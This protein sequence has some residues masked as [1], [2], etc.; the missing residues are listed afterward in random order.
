MKLLSLYIF[1]FILLLLLFLSA[2]CF[3]QTEVNGK[4]TD[5][6][7]KPLAYVNVYIL[8]SFDGSMS[9]KDGSF[10]FI[11]SQNGEIQLVA[12]IIGYEK[13]QNSILLD[14][15]SVNP[16]HL[17]LESSALITKDNIVSV[18]PRNFS[19]LSFLLMSSIPSF[20]LLS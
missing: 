3:A 9:S 2:T 10:S 11:T 12:S 14:T 19:P 5:E 20:Q 15:L 16:I 13:L 18:S 6:E 4:V 17:I 1:K 8:D 7:G